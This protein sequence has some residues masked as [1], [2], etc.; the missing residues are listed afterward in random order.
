[1]FGFDPPERLEFASS[2]V[3]AVSQIP[4][5]T[6]YPC[7]A[8]ASST[9]SM[10]RRGGAVRRGGFPPLLHRGPTAARQRTTDTPFLPLAYIKNSS[11]KRQKIKIGSRFVL[12]NK[13]RNEARCGDGRREDEEA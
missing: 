12:G 9:R 8:V 4:G 10:A 1:M 11:R 3:V 7:M 5:G 2:V 13:R 6:D